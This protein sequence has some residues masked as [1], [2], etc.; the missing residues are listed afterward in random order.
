[1]VLLGMKESLTIE[2]IIFDMDGLMFDTERISLNGWQ[3]SAALYGYEVTEELFKKVIGANID[4]TREVYLDHFGEK[5]PFEII[6]DKKISMGRAFIEK[7]GIAVKKGL[8]ELLEYLDKLNIKKAVA[9]SSSRYRA[10][11]L[12]GL[13][14]VNKHFDY[15]L[16][17]DEVKISKPN[18]EIFLKVAKKMDC[19]PENCIVLEDSELGIMAAAEAGMTSIMVPDMLAPSIK[20]QELYYKKMDNLLEVK[21]FLEAYLEKESIA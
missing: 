4:R 1:M 7:E 15:V 9:T 3:Q 21:D 11:H 18:P 5:F 6:R 8:Y 13:A 14:K 20:I 10:V 2:M 17:G 12:L 16:C 19:K